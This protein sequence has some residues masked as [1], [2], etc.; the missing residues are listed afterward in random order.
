MTLVKDV[1]YAGIDSSSLFTDGKY[2]KRVGYLVVTLGYG[3]DFN[4]AAVLSKGRAV[5]DPKVSHLS[6]FLHPIVRRYVWE[7][8]K[9]TQVDEFHLSEEF[10]AEWN[11]MGN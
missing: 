3:R 7:N 5:V 9:S 8:G 11:T 10:N 4:G 6:N 2:G 1:L